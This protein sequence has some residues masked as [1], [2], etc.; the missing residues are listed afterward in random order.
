MTSLGQYAN[1]RTI[2]CELL[3]ATKIEGEIDLTELDTQSISL[4]DKWKI[5]LDDEDNFIIK[6]EMQNVTSLS[7]HHETGIVTLNGGG[8]GGA[9]NLTDLQDVCATALNGEMFYY[10]GT[11]GKYEF[12]NNIKNENSKIIINDLS[13][14]SSL[15]CPDISTSHLVCHDISTHE[16]SCNILNY[17]SLNPPISTSTNLTDLID[18]CGTAL[19]GDMFFYNATSNKYE[20]TNNIKNDLANDV[21]I[22]R[23]LLVEELGTAHASN[24]ILMNT[25]LDV[26]NNYLMTNYIITTHGLNIYT[27]DGTISYPT[28]F[29]SK[30]IIGA[31]EVGG[32]KERLFL[33]AE[34]VFIGNDSLVKKDLICKDLSCE[35]IFA[36]KINFN[37]L[38][39]DDFSSVEITTENLMYDTCGNTITNVQFYSYNSKFMHQDANYIVGEMVYLQH[40]AGGLIPNGLY[41]VINILYGSHGNVADLFQLSST[42]NGSPVTCSTDSLVNL[43]II[44]GLKIR[45]T[46]LADNNIVI[47]KDQISA[48]TNQGIRTPLII[49]DLSAEEIS[50]NT[51]NTD[52]VVTSSINAPH[53]LYLATELFNIAHPSQIQIN[54]NKIG[55]IDYNTNNDRLYLDG[56][57]VFIGDLL[58]NK[59]DLI[60]KDIDSNSV[61]LNAL[62]VSNG[63]STNA[64]NGDVLTISGSTMRWEQPSAS[65]P[66]ASFSL[67]THTGQFPANTISIVDGS[68]TNIVNSNSITNNNDGTFTINEPGTYL[69][70][71]TIDFQRSPSFFSTAQIYLTRNRNGNVDRLS[72][73][74][75]NDSSTDETELNVDI[76]YIDSFLENDNIVMEG[77]CDQVWQALGFQS[78]PQNMTKTHINVV[79]LS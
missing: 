70:N 42:P 64:Q 2:E 15:V 36:N 32:D 45:P 43:T 24:K 53:S 60:C 41:Y 37:S 48:L 56:S 47:Y 29:F 23:D 1:G 76:C 30:N 74:V 11:S 69:I 67:T 7:A 50:C 57:D 16:I 38:R 17:S 20:F 68:F 62:E 8:G 72:R 18:V 39:T 75:K 31:I 26:S 49:F 19:A 46:N 79:K 65:L 73:S 27:G 13:L 22:I 77:N 28:L 34:D 40:V 51:L 66:S 71:M 21:I 5:Y 9:D 35:E 4:E 33:D 54:S 10:N 61:K 55:A 3:K 59:K 25:S 12:T 6:N 14:T 78:N 58:E 63:V 52:N 44:P